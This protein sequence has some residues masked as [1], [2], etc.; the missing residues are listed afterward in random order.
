MAEEL[1]TISSGLSNWTNS[2]TDLVARDFK[3]NGVAFEDYAKTCAMNAMSSIYQLV[4]S[5]G[6]AMNDMDTSNLREIVG[7]CAS[8]K[9]N[10]NG[11]PRECYFQLR[12]KKVGEKYVKTVEMGIEG[13]GQEAL[14][15]QFGVNVNTV[16]DWWLVKDGDDFVYPK[17]KGLTLTPPEWDPKGL[18]E[19]TVRVVLPIKLTDGNET[20]LIAERESVKTNL[21]AH[22][23]NN[24]MNETFG[25]CQNRYK[26]TDEQKKQID[27]RKEEIYA[28]LRECE[29]LEDMIHCE[30]ALPY[31]SGAWLDTFESMVIRKMQNN[32]VKKFPKNFDNM[33]KQSFVELDDTYKA[34]QEEVAENANAI[35][36]EASEQD[37]ID[38]VSVD[39]DE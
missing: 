27:A 39:I 5:Q 10:A 6:E 19:K 17:R 26:A 15:R 7:Q 14:L 29:T 32:A 2:V 37:I 28:A 38:G 12:T 33:A 18:S 16:Y 34:A 11:Y 35:P 8:L 36:F 22:V 13:A 30:K 20:Y 21:F 1:T 3:L 31:I 4:K 9:L 24:L 23:R 25:I